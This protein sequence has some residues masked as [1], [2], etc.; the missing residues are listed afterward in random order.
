MIALKPQKIIAYLKEH[1]HLFIKYK[2]IIVSVA[3]G[4]HTSQFEKQLA[5]DVMCIRA[6]LSVACSTN[7]AVTGL[8]ANEN[9]SADIYQQQQTF[10]RHVGSVLLLKSNEQVDAFAAISASGPAYVAW[11]LQMLYESAEQL[12]FDTG[13]AEMLAQQ[14]LTGSLSIC[15]FSNNTPQKTLE[16]VCS[17]KGTTQS[18]LEYLDNNKVKDL[19]VNAIKNA[20]HRANEIN[21]NKNIGD[22]NADT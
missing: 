1:Q 17:S 7:L 13:T 2:P 16:A 19:W 21:T 11:F 15:S 20:Y 18:A 6:M 5:Y 9:T 8:Y 14:T 12:G 3:V 22:N 4:F 10:W